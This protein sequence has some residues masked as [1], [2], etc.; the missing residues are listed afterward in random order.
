MVRGLDGL[1]RQL[2]VDPRDA[3]DALYAIVERSARMAL[4]EGGGADPNRLARE[5]LPAFVLAISRD[6]EGPGRAG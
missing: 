6:V 3:A 5:T 4:L 1:G 2:L